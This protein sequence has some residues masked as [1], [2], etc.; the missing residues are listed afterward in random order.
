MKKTPG[1]TPTFPTRTEF[2]SKSAS[3]EQMARDCIVLAAGE[4]VRMGRSKLYL[5]FGEGTLLG[6]TVRQAQCAGLRVIVVARAEDD[7]IAALLGS[8]VV[9][10]RNAYPERGMLSSLR[11]GL[12]LVRSRCFFF[13]PA[14]MPLVS[15]AVYQA[16]AAIGSTH[17]VIP[18][19]HDKPGHPV[20]MP[21]SLI[22]AIMGLPDNV[23][24]KTLIAQARPVFVEVNDE[25]I[26]RD[27]DTPHE[28]QEALSLLRD[29]RTG[30]SWQRSTAANEEQSSNLFWVRSPFSPK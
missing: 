22:P 1:S 10:V 2:Q 14:D 15:P 26:L 30:E 3:A 24:L 9:V 20:L 19:A 23:P 13:I 27:I 6:T 18:T 5:S 28:Y 12:Q 7:Q 4:S 25:S 11:E 29:P 16:M 21:A 8:R 17:P